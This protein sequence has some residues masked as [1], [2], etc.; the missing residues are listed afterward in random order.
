MK[1]NFK[2]IVTILAFSTVLMACKK[3]ADEAKTAEAEVVAE[4]QA[5]SAKYNADIANSTIAWAGSKPTGTH[6]GTINISEG[7][8]TVNNGEIESGTFII[9][10]NSIVDLDIPADK[11]GNARLVGHLKSADFF[12]VE[13]FP[14]AVFE[15]T[16]VSQQEGKTMLAGNL[17]LKSIKNNVTFPVSVASQGDNYKITSETFTIDRSKWEVKYG[18]KSFFDDL[19]DKFINDDIELQITVSATKKADAS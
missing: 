13:K 6:N 5:S 18:S 15:I 14:N 17:T 4:A 7:T 19:G 12:D 3:G 1:R 2:S 9:D 10:M 8:L 11:K 16:G